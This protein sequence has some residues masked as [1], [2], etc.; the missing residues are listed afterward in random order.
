MQSKNNYLV[1]PLYLE[2]NCFFGCDYYGNYTLCQLCDKDKD[3]DE[4]SRIN[5][6]YEEDCYKIQTYYFNETDKF[7]LICKKFK[8]FIILIIDHDKLELIEKK[9]V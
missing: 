4:C 3:F 7:A 1:C 2:K 5:Y 9:I 8:E 6:L